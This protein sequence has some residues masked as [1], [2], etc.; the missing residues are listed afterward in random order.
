MDTKTTMEPANRPAKRTTPKLK[1]IEFDPDPNE[2]LAIR[3]KSFDLDAPEWYLNRELTWLAFNRR[4]L[5]EA[6]DERTPLLER[7]KFLAIV[8]SNLDEFFM[9]R[10]GGL[11]QQVGAGLQEPSVDGRTPAQ[12]I[13]ECFVVVWDLARQLRQLAGE[14]FKRHAEM[15]RPRAQQRVNFFLPH[16]Y[17]IVE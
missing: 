16:G 3:S 15:A 8:H 1:P 12:Q 6:A 13:K 14:L 4:V 2:G 11:K 7:V 10:I 9:K 5:H 17:D